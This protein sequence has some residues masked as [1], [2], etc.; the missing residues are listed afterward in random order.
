MSPR[1]NTFFTLAPNTLYVGSVPLALCHCSSTWIRER[2]PGF[3]KLLCTPVRKLPFN[4]EQAINFNA[5]RIIIELIS[6]KCVIYFFQLITQRE[7]YLN[8][9]IKRDQLD[10]T[11]FFIS[12]FNA[13]HVSDVNTSTFRSLRIIC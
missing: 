11:C 13:Q 2:N 6:T 3:F 5:V 4:V 7:I 8:N 9:R 12:L 1:Q 10:V